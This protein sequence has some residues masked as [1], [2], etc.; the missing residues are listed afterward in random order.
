[1]HR[2]TPEVPQPDFEPR[3]SRTTVPFYA[4]YRLSYPAELIARVADVVGLKPCARVM[5][6]G[7]GPGFLA[8]PFAL[9]GMHVVGVD[10]EPDMLEAARAAA[11]DAGVDV[12]F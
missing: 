5:D 3:R 1:M 4:R 9:A 11:K 7:C 2:E 12:D 10:P 6:L 8:I